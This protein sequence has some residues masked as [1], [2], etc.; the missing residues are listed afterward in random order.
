V[1]DKSSHLIVITGVTRGLG[2]ALAAG[3]AQ[4]GHIVAG[5]GRS[6]EAIESL[7]RELGEPHDLQVVDVMHDTAVRVWARSVLCRH[8]A[9]DLLLNNAG[10]TTRCAALWEIPPEECDRIIDVNIK[11]VINVVRHFVP[12][13][14]ERGSGVIVNFSSGLGRSTSP[15]AA[16][17]C[18]TKWAIEGLSRALAQELPR[19]LAAI[20]LAPGVVDSDLLRTLFGA[21][22]QKHETPHAWAR[23]AVPFLL[24]LGPRKNGKPL[25]IR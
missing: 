3:F 18:A 10:Q 17:Y 20:P 1:R 2:R 22:A 23:K 16:P 4:S 21:A 6:P 25:K 13:M 8:G 15:H 11:G 5:C 24:K 14:I 9:P 19:G 7:R 12:A